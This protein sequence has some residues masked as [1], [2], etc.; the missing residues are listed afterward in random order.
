M[1]LP[2][3]LVFAL[4]L[5]VATFADS[6]A[7]DRPAATPI[8]PAEYAM[9][10]P[11]PAAEPEPRLIQWEYTVLKNNTPLD[12]VS[13]NR[14]GEEGWE[15]VAVVSDSTNNYVYTFKRPERYNTTVIFEQFT[16]VDVIAARYNPKN[17]KREEDIENIALI[18]RRM[19]ELKKDSELNPEHKFINDRQTDELHDVLNSIVSKWR[20]KKEYAERRKQLIEDVNKHKYDKVEQ[21]AMPIER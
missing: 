17:S 14:L 18:K 6:F 8:S 2:A 20:S 1:K 4:L 3:S 15:L 7:E 11:K 12:E 9:G 10:D 19:S 5:S 16:D 21:P 13:L